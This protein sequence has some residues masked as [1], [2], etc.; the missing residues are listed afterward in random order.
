MEKINR[1]CF[2]F[3][4]FPISTFFLQVLTPSTQVRMALTEAW[5]LDSSNAQDAAQTPGFMWSLV[6]P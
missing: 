4:S 2:P 1:T 3:Q 5:P 6:A